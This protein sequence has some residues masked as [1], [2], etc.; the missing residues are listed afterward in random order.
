MESRLAGKCEF[1][2]SFSPNIPTPHG[3]VFASNV[4]CVGIIVLLHLELHH[5]IFSLRTFCPSNE[6]IM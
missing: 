5:V 4:S 6:E 1:R 3:I 2:L